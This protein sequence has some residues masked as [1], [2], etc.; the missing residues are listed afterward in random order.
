MKNVID[1]WHGEQGTFSTNHIAKKESTANTNSYHI[2]SRVGN[3]AAHPDDAIDPPNDPYPA[4]DG[5]FHWHGLYDHRDY[6][7]NR[8]RGVYPLGAREKSLTHSDW[9]AKWSNSVYR[10]LW[11]QVPALY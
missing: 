11:L 3:P 4:A 5:E 7:R 9:M 2:Y 1:I 8:M 6:K 10:L